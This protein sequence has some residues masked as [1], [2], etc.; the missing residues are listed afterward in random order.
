MVPF[1]SDV[2]LPGAGP[3]LMNDLAVAKLAADD[4]L[5]S[6][7]GLPGGASASLEYMPVLGAVGRG[8]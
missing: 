2:K 5:P 8:V 6:L 3:F 7:L 4:V 1:N